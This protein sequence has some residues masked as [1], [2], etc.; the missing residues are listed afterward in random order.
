[1]NL[2]KWLHRAHERLGAWQIFT[3]H[4]RLAKGGICQGACRV[5]RWLCLLQQRGSHGIIAHI[6]RLERRDC[7]THDDVIVV[8]LIVHTGG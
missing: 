3:V 8:V 6:E 5:E 2:F 4:A 1:M 7:L